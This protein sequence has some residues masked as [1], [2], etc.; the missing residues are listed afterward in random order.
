MYLLQDAR[1]IISNVPTDAKCWAMSD[2]LHRFSPSH[3]KFSTAE[4]VKLT[5]AL[6]LSFVIQLSRYYFRIKKSFAPHQKPRKE[7]FLRI[8]WKTRRGVREVG[9][10]EAK[11]SGKS[12]CIQWSR[13]T[14]NN[15]NDPEKR[16][17]MWKFSSKRNLNLA[18]FRLTHAMRIRGKFEKKKNH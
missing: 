4:K 6:F 7:F 2:M 5:A 16:M 3:T 8:I 1:V 12:I 17:K 10:K 15:N 9:V 11:K 14:M 13:M 18:N